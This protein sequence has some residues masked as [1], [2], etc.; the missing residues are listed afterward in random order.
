M[1]R[2]SWDPSPEDPLAGRVRH[3]GTHSLGRRD[4]G[5]TMSHRRRRRRLLDLRLTPVGPE[6][7]KYGRPRPDP[8][9][10]GHFGDLGYIPSDGKFSSGG[11]SEGPLVLRPKRGLQQTSLGVP[12]LRPRPREISLEG[13]GSRPGT[14]GPPVSRYPPA[15]E[16]PGGSR[17]GTR[18]L[19]PSRPPP[20]VSPDFHGYISVTPL[21]VSVRRLYG[22]FGSRPAGVESVAP[23]LPSGRDPTPTGGTIRHFPI[24]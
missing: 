19:R 14:V 24:S 9:Q 4:S 20:L 10:P 17:T 3:T 15:L 2:R 5:R 13:R 11:T 23:G 7:R 6:R 18:T 16:D 1:N 21:A 12:P 22:G 8:R